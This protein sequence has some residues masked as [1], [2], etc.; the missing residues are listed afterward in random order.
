M[1]AVSES[2]SSPEARSHI[3]MTRSP[4]PVENHWL[5]GFTATLRTQPRWPNITR[6]TFRG[7]WYV[8]F[9]ARVV[10]CSARASTQTGMSRVGIWG[11]E[12]I[13]EVSLSADA[14]RRG[15]SLNRCRQRMETNVRPAVIILHAALHPETR[16]PNRSH[17]GEKGRRKF[18]KVS[19]LVVDFDWQTYPCTADKL[20]HKNFS[21]R[22]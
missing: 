2:F 13:R 4:A 1:W 6:T 17:L 3:L 21:R 10:L 5:P 20:R 7:A 15:A 11:A 18:L 12:I 14:A 19:V 8:G 16:G 9:I 22:L